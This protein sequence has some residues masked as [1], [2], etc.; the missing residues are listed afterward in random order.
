MNKRMLAR[1]AMV[2]VA[3]GAMTLLQGCESDDYAYTFIW[4]PSTGN[5]SAIFVSSGGGTW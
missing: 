4:A 5:S 3:V 2:I 1:L